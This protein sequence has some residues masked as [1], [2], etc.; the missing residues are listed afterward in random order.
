MTKKQIDRL[1]KIAADFP[2]AIRRLPPEQRRKYEEA[3]HSVTEARK[4]GER[5]ARNLWIG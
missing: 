5:A 4:A 1:V 2:A 3:Q